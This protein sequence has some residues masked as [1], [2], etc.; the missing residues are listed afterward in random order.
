MTGTDVG[1]SAA[2]SR[3]QRSRGSSLAAGPRVTLFEQGTLGAGASGRNTGTLLHQT[4]PAVAAMLRASGGSLRGARRRTSRWTSRDE[5]LLARDAVAA[6]LIAAK[7]RASPRRAWRSSSDGDELR[8]AFPA[9]GPDVLG[10]QVLDGAS[11][12]D[13]EPATRA[14]AEAAREA[15]ARDPHRRVPRGRTVGAAGVLTD[16]G[17]RGGRRRRRSPPARGWPISSRR[18]A[19]GRAAGWLMRTRTPAFDVPWIVEEVSW[20][21]QAR[22]RPRRR[23]PVALADSPPAGSTAVGECALICPLPGGDALLGASL[24][25]LAARRRRGHRR[26]AADRRRACSRSRRASPARRRPR[27]GR[28]CGR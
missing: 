28:G 6:A 19:C 5:L 15:G 25:D 10:G 21:D 16:E 1:S 18:A 8:A 17:P 20:P 14:F 27:A 22:A 26:A 4:E 13:A 2:A 12:V 23:E 9:F 7:G 3:A 11:T 24:V